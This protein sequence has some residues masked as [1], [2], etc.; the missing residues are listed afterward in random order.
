MKRWTISKHL[1]LAYWL[2]IAASVVMNVNGYHDAG[3]AVWWFAIDLQFS[4]IIWS[5]LGFLRDFREA[6]AFSNKVG[7]IDAAVKTG[8]ISHM[9][10]LKKLQALSRENDKLP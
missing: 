10:A 5:C 6:R 4:I 8:T 1:M 9:E 2:I 7:A 3:N